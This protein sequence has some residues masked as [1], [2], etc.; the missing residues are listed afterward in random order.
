M[1]NLAVEVQSKAGLQGLFSQACFGSSAPGGDEGRESD[2]LGIL[3]CYVKVDSF[4]ASVTLLGHSISAIITYL[5][6]LYI[7]DFCVE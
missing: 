5:L 2:I 3:Q 6:V 7:T 1:G 4:L